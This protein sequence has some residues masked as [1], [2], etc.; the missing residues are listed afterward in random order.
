VCAL[1]RGDAVLVGSCLLLGDLPGAGFWELWELLIILADNYNRTTE[2]LTKRGIERTKDAQRRPLN[3][4]S[5]PFSSLT[6]FAAVSSRAG[7][8]LHMRSYAATY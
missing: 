5:E 1:G 2:D 4:G 3:E 8:R 6:I 7:A